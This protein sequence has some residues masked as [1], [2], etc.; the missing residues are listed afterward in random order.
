MKPRIGE[1]RLYEGTVKVLYPGEQAQA[2]VPADDI[3]SAVLQ[4]RRLGALALQIDPQRLQWFVEPIPG[5]H[6][7]WRR[8]RYRVIGQWVNTGREPG[9]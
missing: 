3:E 4:A 9:W 8:M 2:I 7:W 6:G 1:P 5:W